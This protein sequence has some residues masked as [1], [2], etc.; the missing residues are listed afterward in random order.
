MSVRIFPSPWAFFA[1]EQGG[2]VG[3]QSVHI[4]DSAVQ[5]R[6]VGLVP[7]G[8]TWCSLP[9]QPA[10]LALTRGPQAWDVACPRSGEQSHAAWS[11]GHSEVLIT[12]GAQPPRASDPERDTDPREVWLR[13]QLQRYAE[14]SDLGGRAE[15]MEAKLA[16]G[17]RR[18]W[19][20]V[21]RNW[22]QDGEEQAEMALVVELAQDM[23][24]IRAL[25]AIEHSP[26]RML[27]RRHEKV[28]L[29]RIQEMDSG[30][31][32]AYSQA[33]GR[34]AVQKA[35]SKQELLAVVR[36]DTVDLVENRILIWSTTRLSSM[37]A[38]YCRRNYR[39][40][41]S[42]RFQA[43]QGLRGLCLRVTRSAHLQEVG[44][45]PHHLD[46]PTYCLQFERRYRRLWW[47]Y[48]RIRRQD[49]LED[50]AWQ[51]QTRLWGTS[52]RLILA[53]MLLSLRGWSEERMST[54]YIQNEGVCGVWIDGPYVPGPLV[55]PFGKCQIIDL[56][57]SLG[58]CGREGWQLPEEAWACGAD[59][60]L[61][62][63]ERHRLLVLWTAV[64][65]GAKETDGGG[66]G[67]HALVARLHELSQST[68]WEWGAILFIAEPVLAPED[69]DPLDADPRL[70]TLRVPRDVHS[71]WEDVQA[72]LELAIQELHHA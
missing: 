12:L 44:A 68:A 45:L 43:V 25:H 35:G 40:K 51:W 18:T 19:A 34:N 61:V 36:R 57:T 32:R 1:G 46:A 28:K 62:W 22:R 21:A 9:P 50:D 67:R 10:S 53:S 27:L 29:S 71:R 52:A 5:A 47:A 56:R 54:P 64:A 30:A 55:T 26:R 17:A 33:P 15:A 72:G 8:A 7:S 3:A 4:A 66:L 48:R 38:A 42:D 11:A 58:D 31:L 49:R 63:P 20:S 13:W 70:V 14:L 69:V 16:W 39:F 24:F 59:W 60:L 23:R 2:E 65:S 37:A 6:L 41:T